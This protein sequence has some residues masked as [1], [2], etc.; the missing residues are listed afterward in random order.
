MAGACICKESIR[1]KNYGL[2]GYY[3][4]VQTDIQTETSVNEGFEVYFS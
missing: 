3:L 2:G 4:Q 1:L